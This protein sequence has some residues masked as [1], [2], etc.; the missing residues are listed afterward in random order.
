MNIYWSSFC[1]DYWHNSTNSIRNWL[2]FYIDRRRCF[3]SVFFVKKPSEH[4]T[5]NF[6]KSWS[7]CFRV[8]MESGIA[9]YQ[10]DSKVKLNYDLSDWFNTRNTL[11]VVG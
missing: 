8:S 3:D 1:I 2:I 6:L 11:C 4:L 9:V 5:P 10:V 7:E